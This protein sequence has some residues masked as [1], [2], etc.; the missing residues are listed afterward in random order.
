MFVFI[1]FLLKYIKNIE[2]LILGIKIYNFIRN[3]DIYELQ[4]FFKG[5]IK[6]LW[7]FEEG[8]IKFII[9]GFFLFL[10]C[11]KFGINDLIKFRQEVENY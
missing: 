2:F 10:L 8:V 5:F 6:I 1:L 7:F 4:Y 3:K 11:I 9:Y